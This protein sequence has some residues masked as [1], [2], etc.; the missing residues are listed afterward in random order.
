MGY[1]SQRNIAE[2]LSNPFDR[3]KKTNLCSEILSHPFGILSY[4]NFWN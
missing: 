3:I 1:L 4:W 2:I